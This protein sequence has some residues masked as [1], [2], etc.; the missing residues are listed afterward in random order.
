MPEKILP[1]AI[2]HVAVEDIPANNKAMAKIKA[3]L[4]PKIGLNNSVACAKSSTCKLFVKNTLAAIIIIALFIAQ[5]SPIE[6]KVSKNS[7]FNCR[8]IIFHLANSIDAIVLLLNVKI[9][10][11]A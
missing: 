1:P 7:Y 10:Y 6:N 5:P 8:F 4:S 2:P 11:V 3:A 9:N